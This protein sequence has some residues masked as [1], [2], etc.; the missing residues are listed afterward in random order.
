MEFVWVMRKAGVIVGVSKN[1]QPGRMEEKLSAD[2]AEVIA[3]LAEPVPPRPRLRKIPSTGNT[4]A[5]L[6]AE[7]NKIIQYLGGT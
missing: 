7:I 1:R 3:Y 2:D 5:S 6:S 4:V